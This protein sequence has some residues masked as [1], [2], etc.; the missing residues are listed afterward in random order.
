MNLHFTH[1]GR[2]RR[3]NRSRRGHRGVHTHTHAHGLGSCTLTDSADLPAARQPA[4]VSAGTFSRINNS[5]K[6]LKLTKGSHSLGVAHL[7]ID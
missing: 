6:I 5:S 7:E 4:R 2:C 3:Y 1:L